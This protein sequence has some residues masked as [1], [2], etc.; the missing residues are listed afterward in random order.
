MKNIM[1]IGFFILFYFFF[2]LSFDKKNIILFICKY[3]DLINRV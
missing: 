3:L 2:F 1:D